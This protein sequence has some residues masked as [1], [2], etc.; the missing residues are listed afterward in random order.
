MVARGLSSRYVLAFVVFAAVAVTALAAGRGLAATF[1]VTTTV[2]AVDADPGDGACATAR[3]PCSLRAAVQEA[4]ALAGADR[5]ILLPGVYPLSLLGSGEDAA[6]TGDLDVTDTLTVRGLNAFF[7]TIDG[8]GADRVFDAF[9]SALTLRHVRVFNG[10]ASGE[11]AAGHGGGIRFGGSL[12]LDHAIV[13]GNRSDRDGGGIAAVDTGPG[14]TLTI[15]RS[16]ISLNRAAP[17]TNFGNGGGIA[18]YDG[19][20][21]PVRADIADSIII[22]N[23][24]H[25][26]GGGVIFG[27]T[28]GQEPRHTI[29]NTIVYGNRAGLA[30]EDEGIGGGI[31]GNCVRIERS[32]I[33]QNTAVDDAGGLFSGC[34]EVV[35]ST[36]SGNLAF[37]RG[38]GLVADSIG[39]SLLLLHTTVAGNAVRA[40]G[41]SSAGVE[42]FGELRVQNSIIDNAEGNCNAEFG[43]IIDLGFNVASDA[44]CGLGGSSLENT[45]PMLL[46]VTNNGGFTPTAALP[47]DSP[48]VDFVEDAAGVAIDQRG[49]ARPQGPLSDAGAFEFDG[50]RRFAPPGGFLAEFRRIPDG[51]PPGLRDALPRFTAAA[52]QCDLDRDQDVDFDDL[53]LVIARDRGDGGRATPGDGRQLARCVA[54]C[55]RPGCER[56]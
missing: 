30:P 37:D 14:E 25:D 53:D 40:A 10:S 28:V 47:A 1:L 21:A 34:G 48:A 43:E 49:V 9:G 42:V 32:W 13:V 8:L 3:G 29:V 7:T 23:V 16:I 19:S 18:A 38:G 2:D 45:D 5:V 33:A 46:P 20:P 6:A 54:L 11:E 12:T 52:S 27:S 35:N 4:N 24:A 17:D 36:I 41:A 39:T 31:L 44:T 15:F 50:R 26:A 55:T 22:A 56:Q 51:V